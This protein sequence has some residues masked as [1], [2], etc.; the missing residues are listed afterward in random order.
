MA[1]I[2]PAVLGGALIGLETILIKKARSIAGIFPDV[3]I[4]EIHHDELEITN[5]P[6]SQGGAP[7]VISDHAFKRPAELGMRVGWSPSGS[8][9]N[10][11]S[12]YIYDVYQQLL[13]L[14]NT[15]EPFE[16]STG[17]RSYESMML[18]SLA[19]VT[20][21]ETE[22]CLMVEARFQ[23]VIIVQVRT[24]TLPPSLYQATPQK[25]AEPQD[26]GTVQP[27]PVVDRTILKT[28]VD[29]V[30]GVGN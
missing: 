15:R 29:I 27:T 5:H 26:T 17:K 10:L 24:T 28:I 2:I 30:K 12:D 11:G 4:E 1:S 3:V 6:V 14:Q 22:N 16:I 20:N 8:V 19:V 18:R 23:Q 21:K 9:F 7:N 13:D 25:T